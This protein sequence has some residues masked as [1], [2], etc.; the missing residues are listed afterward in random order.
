MSK[1]VSVLPASV[2]KAVTDYSNVSVKA[3]NS[4]AKVLDACIKE[5]YHW[6]DLQAPKKGESRDVYDSFRFAIVQG[7][8]STVRKLLESPTKSLTEAKKGE[9][10]Y[11][12]QQIG[13]KMKDLRN[14]L[15]KRQES[16]ESSARA[17]K[18]LNTKLRE[19]LDEVVERIQKA[20]GDDIKHALG[21]TQ[22]ATFIKDTRSL[23]SKITK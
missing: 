2:T 12:Q 8:N 13:S 16:S 17:P 20:E 18:A 22:L 19:L 1:F 5:G 9:K 7:F 14:A 15:K 3:G 6:T 10:K 23:Q 21:D 4:L 11:W